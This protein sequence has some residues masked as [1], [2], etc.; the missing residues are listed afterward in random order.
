[1]YLYYYPKLTSVL[2]MHDDRITVKAKVNELI[3]MI[4]L[5][6]GDYAQVLCL[7]KLEIMFDVRFFALRRLGSE[8]LFFN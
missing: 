8:L 4:V 2:L 7:L 1:M 3:C 6:V 5:V